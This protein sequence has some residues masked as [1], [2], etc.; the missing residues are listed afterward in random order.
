MSRRQ[1]FKPAEREAF[2]PGTRIEWLHGSHWQPGEITGEMK[3][4]PVLGSPYYPCVHKGKTT[5]T[6]SHGAFLWGT[7]GGIRLPQQG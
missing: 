3:I 6:I 4:D 2:K 7:P 5:R 1:R